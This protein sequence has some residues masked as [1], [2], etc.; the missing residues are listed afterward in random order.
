MVAC[1][2]NGG[3]DRGLS[4]FRGESEGVP[5]PSL[6]NTKIAMNTSLKAKV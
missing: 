6:R 5:G 2:Y 3:G 1:I 4:K